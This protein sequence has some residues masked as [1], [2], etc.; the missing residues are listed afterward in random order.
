LL[1]IAI[2]DDE[3]RIGRGL[4]KIVRS[5]SDEYEVAG[6]F[7]N[8]A[9]LLRFVEEEGADVVITD[10]RMP[11]MDGLKVAEKLHA[12]HP[13]V[14][15]VI[16]SGYSDFDY[17]RTAMRYQVR[18]YLLKPVDKAELYR[19]LREMAK[20]VA[21]AR[22]QAKLVRRL[23]LERALAGDASAE[24]VIPDRAFA[25]WYAV[26]TETAVELDE[27][28]AA[29]H[30]EDGAACAVA[31]RDRAYGV[32]LELRDG[33]SLAAAPER[34]GY[35]LAA[36]LTEKTGA[37]IG[38]SLP[39]RGAARLREAFAEAELAAGKAFYRFERAVFVSA[40]ESAAQQAK[41]ARLSDWFKSW[42]TEF[43]RSLQILETERIERELTAFFEEMRRR[44]E[45]PGVLPEL[46]VRLIGLAEREVGGFAEEAEEL[47]GPADRRLDGLSRF[48]KYDPLRRWFTERMIDAM[49]RIRERR[50]GSVRAVDAVKAII[51]SGYHEELDLASL[52]ERVYLT[53]SYLSRL[54]KQETGVTITD[55][56][57]GVRIEQAKK[58]LRGRPDL[59]TYEVGERV[60]YPDSAYFN[61]LFKRIV[62]MTP[63]EYRQIAR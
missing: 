56:L 43:V 29:A 17:A 7:A 52:A 57:I 5:A 16:V 34:A 51:A 27:L 46:L 62:G 35:A 25:V 8:G 50:S 61:K 33:A 3:E 54:F 38:V 31:V 26:R 44:Q 15:C 53:P 47:F 42:E 37:A 4:A 45:P 36:A 13:G 30:S 28:E 58:L 9:E 24:P 10:I 22:R 11:V 2:A 59:K 21:E 49:A 63:N 41:P 6:V 40:S 12:E 48:F 23:K 18:D 19:V 60:G 55:Y 32:L 1:R 14:R 39:F 20:D